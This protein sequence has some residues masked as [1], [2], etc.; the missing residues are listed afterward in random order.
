ML[1]Q[2]LVDEALQTF[3]LGGGE[4]KTVDVVP[5]EKRFQSLSE[6]RLLQLHQVLSPSREK[7][8]QVFIR[9][10]APRAATASDVVL[11]CPEVESDALAE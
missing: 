2:R 8:P 6:A 3:R 1:S 9:S 11:W 4:G 10:V 5:L 7:Q